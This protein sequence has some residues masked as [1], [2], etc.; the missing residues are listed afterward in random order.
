MCVGVFF[1]C[2]RF[3]SVGHKHPH[4]CLNLTFIKACVLTT[5]AFTFFQMLKLDDQQFLGEATCA[6]S[7]VSST[8]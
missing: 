6:L 7:E 4:A 3:K 1:F 5:E 8:A 2:C